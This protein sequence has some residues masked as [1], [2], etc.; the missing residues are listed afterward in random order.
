LNKTI[1][2]LPDDRG[3]HVFKALTEA[4]NESSIYLTNVVRKF[5][6]VGYVDITHAIFQSENS[7]FMVDLMPLLEEAFYQAFH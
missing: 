6:F 2:E 4:Q 5:V 3:K 1:G 7:M